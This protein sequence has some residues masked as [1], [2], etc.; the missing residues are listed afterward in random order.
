VAIPGQANGSP[1]DPI[2]TVVM[3]FANAHVRKLALIASVASLFAGC[4][5][6]KINHDGTDSVEHSG[7]EDVGKQLANR[8]C[9]KAGAA[10]AEIISTVPKDDSAPEGKGRSVTSF[11]C[12]Y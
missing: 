10:R 11:R 2:W 7:G 12:I 1:N 6:V 5:V 3:H 8:A 4:A 9:K